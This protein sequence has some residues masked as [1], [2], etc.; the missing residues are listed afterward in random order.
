MILKSVRV[1]G[2]TEEVN[3]NDKV[4]F[5]IEQGQKGPNAVNV[6]KAIK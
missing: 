1:N 6:K 4:T 5:E 2:L 3:E